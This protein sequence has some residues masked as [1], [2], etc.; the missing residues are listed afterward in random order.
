MFRIMY[1]LKNVI[2]DKGFCQLLRFF[3]FTTF[4]LHGF[5]KV[6]PLHCPYLLLWGQS[7]APSKAIIAVVT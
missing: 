5:P 1:L 7:I 2:F 6:L 3:C 4:G